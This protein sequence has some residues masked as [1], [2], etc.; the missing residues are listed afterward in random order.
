[1]LRD[2]IALFG[3]GV[4]S[5]LAPCVVPLVPA[6]LGMVAGESGDAHDASRAVP[7]TG[8]FVLGFATVFAT[9]GVVAGLV[10]RSLSPVQDI[11]QR[12][13]GV[14]IIIFGLALLAYGF[15]RVLGTPA[16]LASIGL[17][18]FAAVAQFVPGLVAGVA[19]RGA[20]RDGVFWGL[21]V[22]A[23][24]WGYTLMLPGLLGTQHPLV[25]DGA[26]GLHVLRPQAL[27][28]LLPRGRRV[29]VRVPS[30]IAER[31]KNGLNRETILPPV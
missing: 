21:L 24:L 19:W 22:G 3:A 16:S 10:G 25:I 17:M 18:A 28:G 31:G 9:F 11:V 26:F 2:Y 27:F 4:A 1:M 5:F 7:A 15:Y 13:G 30:P 6:Y 12:V 29:H 8:I 23:L 14:V 20:T